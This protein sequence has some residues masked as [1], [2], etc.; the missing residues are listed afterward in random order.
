MKTRYK[1]LNSKRKIKELAEGDLQHYSELARQLRYGGNPEHKKN[2]GDFGLTP[3]SCPRPG[4]SLCDAVCIFSRK[5]ALNHLKSGLCKGL[6]S[7][8]F[9]GRWPQN[10]WSVTENG[11]P[12]E[13]Q[14]ENPATGTYHGYPMPESDPLAAEI[15]RQWNMKND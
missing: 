9:N 10:I 1:Q 13:A 15:V 5:V 8:R 3:P 14:L 11:C 4:K 12:L 6:I 2:P 7:D